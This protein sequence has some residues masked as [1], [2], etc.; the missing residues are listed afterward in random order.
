MAQY[1]QN[2]ITVEAMQWTGDNWQA[3]K[4]WFESVHAAAPGRLSHIPDTTD[5]L[6]ETYSLRAPIAV[7]DW[8]I[9]NE[10]GAV[11]MCN[12]ETFQQRF[13]YLSETLDPDG[14][15]HEKPLMN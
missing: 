6:L 15:T 13:T 14:G 4:A 5:L 1:Q 7:S 8:I 10:N 2:P 9:A 12:D 3:V 11:Y